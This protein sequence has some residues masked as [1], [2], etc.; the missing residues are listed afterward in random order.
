MERLLFNSHYYKVWYENSQIE[1]STKIAYTSQLRKFERYLSEYG[2]EGELDF[3]RFYYSK[4]TDRYAPIDVEFFDDFVDHLTQEYKSKNIYNCICTVKHFM[5]FLETMNL[6]KNNPIRYYKNRFNQQNIRDCSLSEEQCLSLLHAAYDLDPDFRQWYLLILLMITCG[7]R[8]SE[9]CCLHRSQISIELGTI[10][11]DKGQK[12][13]PMSSAST[14]VLKKE[15]KDYFNHSHW[16]EWSKGKDKQVFF[17]GDKPLTYPNLRKVLLGIK[18]RANIQ[19]N[20]TPHDL[21]HTMASLLLK[22]GVD[23]PTIQRQLRHKDISTT[24]RYLPPA[25]AI[26]DQ[27][28]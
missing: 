11:V 17:I 24:L 16:E 22:G 27:L 20:V 14:S 7:L 18:E 3:D 10:A 5:D 9:V 26:A 12:T 23:I 28:K 21:R 13:S 8:A 2:Y 15:F 4:E 19:R 1:V 6:I 25:A